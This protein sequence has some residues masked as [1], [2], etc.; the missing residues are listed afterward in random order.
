[1][2]VIRW[3][4][5][6]VL[7][8][9]CLRVAKECSTFGEIALS[10]G[11][12][13]ST[14]KR[15]R[16]SDSQFKKAVEGLM[17]EGAKEV[18]AKGLKRLAEGAVQVEE[19]EE[20]LDVVEVEGEKDRIIKR[21]RTVKELPPNVQAISKLAN[22]FCKG[23]YSDESGATITTIRITQRDRSLTT[24][25]RL[26]ILAKDEYIDAE[27]ID[28]TEVRNI[29]DSNIRELEMVDDP[30]TEDVIDD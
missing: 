11:I 15:W 19:V 7:K 30:P 6:E 5:T 3:Q 21:K 24:K 12:N 27:A 23:E 13:V 20:W 2:R 22:R 29:G 25:E 18:I 16:D 14:L 10:C 26:A 9:R 17:G 8:E 4:D 28:I 1:M